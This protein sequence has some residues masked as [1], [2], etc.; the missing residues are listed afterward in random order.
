VSKRSKRFVARK[1]RLDLTQSAVVR[2]TLAMVGTQIMG[3]PMGAAQRTMARNEPGWDTD[4]S[5][6][7]YLEYQIRW[8]TREMGKCGPNETGLARVLDDMR[9]TWW[10]QIRALIAGKAS[11]PDY[12]SATYHPA[13][14]PVGA[15]HRIGSFEAWS[16][17]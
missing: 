13:Y 7:A 5:L 16:R 12:P 14:V 4:W 3:D 15:K 2:Q 10:A 9:Q 8:A 6:V 1:V 11:K 17:R